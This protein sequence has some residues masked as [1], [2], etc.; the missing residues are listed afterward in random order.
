MS[1]KKKVVK[2]STKKV[3]TPHEENMERIPNNPFR[4]DDETLAEFKQRRAVETRQTK[5]YIRSRKV[6]GNFGK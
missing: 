3:K 4:Q 2:K 6:L 5:E 1:T